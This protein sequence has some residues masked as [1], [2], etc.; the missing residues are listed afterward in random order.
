MINLLPSDLLLMWTVSLLFAMWKTNSFHS[1][2]NLSIMVISLFI[3][4]LVHRLFSNPEDCMRGMFFVL[5]VTTAL[6]WREVPKVN[7][8]RRID[9]VT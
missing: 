4:A 7:H 9:D 3:I 1:C 2:R 6:V 5:A 8:G